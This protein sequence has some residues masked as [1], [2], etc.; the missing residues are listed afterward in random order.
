VRPF[1][2][3]A[4]SLCP[5]VDLRYPLSSLFILGD[6]S[7][8][9]KSAHPP[10]SSVSQV[11]QVVLSLQVSSLLMLLPSVI[12]L[13]FWGWLWAQSNSILGLFESH[14]TCPHLF[15]KVLQSIQDE[16]K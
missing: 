4:P 7:R 16:V 13:V 6:L 14:F 5:L 12:P 9:V 1:F 15:P 11:N 2:L 8:H 3:M 10:T